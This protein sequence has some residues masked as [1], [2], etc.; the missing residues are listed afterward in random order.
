MT[1]QEV[2]TV[3][4]SERD[5]QDIRWTGHQHEVAG[6]ITMLQ[7]YQ[8]KLVAGWTE[9]AG[10]GAALD[11]MRKIAGIAVHCMEV[12]GAPMRNLDNVQPAV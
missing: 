3:I 12:H 5:Y 10:D 6:Y 9:N 1:R 4:D 11:I 7:H 2:Y 8:A